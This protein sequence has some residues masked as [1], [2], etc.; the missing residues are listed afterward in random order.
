MS[1]V[2][3]KQV[4]LPSNNTL[5]TVGLSNGTQT[6]PSL[7]F[8]EEQNTGIYKVTANQL[9]ISAQSGLVLNHVGVAN[10]V[11]YAQFTNAITSSSPVLMWTGSDA[12]VS[13]YYR[14][15][16]AANHIFDTNTNVTQ[17]R[18]L[19]TASAVNYATIT[20]SATGGC[21]AFGVSGSDTNANVQINPKGT[22][23]IYL[24]ASS[25]TPTSSSGVVRVIGGA[26]NIQIELERPST[27]KCGIGYS[28][29]G[30][31]IYNTD[32]TPVSHFQVS[33]TGDV[34][35]CSGQGSESL[36]AVR[37]ASAVNR[38][39]ITGATTT[40]AVSVLAAGTD[41]NID[42]RLGGKGTGLPDFRGGA[43][44]TAGAV[45]ATGYV[46]LKVAGTTYKFAVAT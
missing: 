2:I 45:A 23:F 27:N 30:F 13:G 10:G 33:T 11:N 14:V 9:G 8:T 31:V 16:G 39:E 28:A 34:S 4:V 42:L 36:R 41:T 6:E 3:G 44:Y 26:S 17:F 21:V 7:F 5:G 32:S 40:N 37:V 25:T 24:G 19:H 38:V 22:G 35:L 46:S 12:S 43:S 20:G 1:V 29:S 15:K 18:V